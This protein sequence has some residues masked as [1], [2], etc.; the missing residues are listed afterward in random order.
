MRNLILGLLV[1]SLSACVDKFKDIKAKELDENEKLVLIASDFT[2]DGNKEKFCGLNVKDS[3]SIYG[4]EIVAKDFIENDNLTLFSLS[5]EKNLNFNHIG[6]FKTGLLYNKARRKNIEPGLSFKSQKGKIIYP[7]TVVVDWESEGFG[8]A[9]L[10]NGG[11]A[12]SE[13]EGSLIM[14]REDRSAEIITKIKEENPELLKKFEF[15]TIKF[16][17]NKNIIQ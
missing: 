11:G 16:E 1:V 6:C 8:F 13:D 15:K 3:P 14:K 2:F 17:E 10:L 12:I 5:K 4:L 7:G 9:D